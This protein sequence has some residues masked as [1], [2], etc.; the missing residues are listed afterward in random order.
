MRRLIGFINDNEAGN[1]TLWKEITAAVRDLDGIVADEIYID[2]ETDRSIWNLLCYPFPRSS[3]I[4]H[5]NNF[6]KAPRSHLSRGYSWKSS[7]RHLNIRQPRNNIAVGSILKELVASRLCSS[8]DPE[9]SIA[10]TKLRGGRSGL[11]W[12]DHEGEREINRETRAD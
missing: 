3:T 9:I 4:R 8:L 2:R 10:S 6:N 11:I 7:L 1:C 12:G 5:R